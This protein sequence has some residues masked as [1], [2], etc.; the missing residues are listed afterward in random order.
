MSLALCFVVTQGEYETSES[1]YLARW[2]SNNS[3]EC[4]AVAVK[5]RDGVCCRCEMTTFLK[6]CRCEKQS[7]LPDS[8]CTMVGKAMSV[9]AKC[10]VGEKLRSGHRKIQNFRSYEK[11]WPKQQNG[12]GIRKSHVHVINGRKSTLEIWLICSDKFGDIVT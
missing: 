7:L 6:T 2:L 10:P 3:G 11:K 8:F 9:L 1:T 5:N 12:F 4:A